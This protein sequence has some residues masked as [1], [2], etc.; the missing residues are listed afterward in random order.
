GFIAQ[1]SLRPE[2]KINGLDLTF[3]QGLSEISE[4]KNWHLSLWNAPAERSGDGDWSASVL[5]CK[6]QNVRPIA[7][8]ASEDACAPVAAALCRRTPNYAC[9]R[10]IKSAIERRRSVARSMR[11]RAPQ[12][13]RWTTSLCVCVASIP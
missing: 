10:R 4:A 11:F 7:L 1:I 5:A 8:I 3:L 12:V 6:R 9:R 2:K 13:A